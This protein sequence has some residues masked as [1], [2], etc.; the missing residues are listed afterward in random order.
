[1]FYD[2]GTFLTNVKQYD[3]T[4]YQTAWLHIQQGPIYLLMGVCLAVLR[5]E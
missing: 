5:C 1:M 3:A 2:Y 4:A